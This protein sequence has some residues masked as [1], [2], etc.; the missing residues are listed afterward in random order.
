MNVFSSIT[1]VFSKV[2]NQTRDILK[3]NVPMLERINFAGSNTL[4]LG[5]LSLVRMCGS[6]LKEKAKGGINFASKGVR[7]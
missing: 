6:L 5:A 4:F 2:I 3:E 1:N 7:F